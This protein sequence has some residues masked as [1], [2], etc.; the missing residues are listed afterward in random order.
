MGKLMEFSDDKII[1]NI[2][3]LHIFI[4]FLFFDDN[5]WIDRRVS[6]VK[7]V[8]ELNCDKKDIFTC[9]LYNMHDGWLA[10]H[11]AFGESFFF[12]F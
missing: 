4:Y 12:K 7:P 9:I 11:V 10:Q 2:P 1:L 6:I 5:K 8:K 3:K